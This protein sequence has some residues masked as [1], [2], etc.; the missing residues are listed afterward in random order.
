ML[1]NRVQRQSGLK[2]RIFPKVLWRLLTKTARYGYR[3]NLPEA[4]F[5]LATLYRIWQETIKFSTSF[6]DREKI[7]CLINM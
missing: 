1:G 5:Q 3:R 2:G 6:F 4:N 7:T